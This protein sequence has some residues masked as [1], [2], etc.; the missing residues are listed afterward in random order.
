MEVKKKEKIPSPD[1]VIVLDRSSSMQGQ[2][3]KMATEAAIRTVK[4]L[5]EDDTFGLIAF[6][7]SPREV[8]PLAP[9]GDKTATIETI[10]SLNTGG[11]TE[12]SSS[13]QHAYNALFGQD[14]ARK[15]IVLLTDGQ[16]PVGSDFYSVFEKG[17][18]E[19]ITLTTVA[20]G[21]DA[22]RQLLEQLA[23]ESG[24]NFYDVAD[25]TTIPAIFTRK[26]VKLIRTYI[27]DAPFHPVLQ[28]VQPW[29]EI[30]RSG[31]PRMNAY[32]ATTPKT[33]TRTIIEVMNKTRF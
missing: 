3:L 17:L 9:L 21:Q 27:V 24:G 15:H 19:N 33:G 23:K 1:L 18:E 28:P 31:M 14:F 2:M 4:L 13:L 8:V 16:A 29:T 11:G 32:V 22:D 26:T 5:R 10:R 12:I 30:F 20:I 7:S 25:E 6:D